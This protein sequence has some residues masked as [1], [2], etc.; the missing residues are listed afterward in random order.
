[1]DLRVG[2]AAEV[3]KRRKKRKRVEARDFD[4]ID[5]ALYGLKRTQ[6]ALKGL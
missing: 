6:S 5:T 4:S 1:M 2:E 3:P